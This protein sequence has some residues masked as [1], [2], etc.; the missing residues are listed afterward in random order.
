MFVDCNVISIFVLLQLTPDRNKD[1]SNAQ[2]DFIKAHN[3]DKV[4]E[5]MRQAVL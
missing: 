1:L 5:L 2:I 4:S 3:S